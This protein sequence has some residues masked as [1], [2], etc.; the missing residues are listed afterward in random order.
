[1]VEITVQLKIFVHKC[2]GWNTTKVR[3]Y[4]AISSTLLTSCR[5][6]FCGIIYEQIPFNFHSSSSQVFYGGSGTLSH[7]DLDGGM[8]GVLRF[9]KR[10]GGVEKKEVPGVLRF[11]K[12]TNKKSM[13]GVCRTLFALTTYFAFHMVRLKSFNLGTPSL[14]FQECSDSVNEACLV[15]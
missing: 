10:E 15:F 6:I 8:P 2:I 1:M 9:G 4:S 12:R 13:P 7:S 14:L 5:C 11:G 3:S